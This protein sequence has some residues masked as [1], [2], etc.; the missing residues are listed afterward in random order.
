MV[1]KLDPLYPLVW[2]S[3]TSLQL[4]VAAPVVVLDDVTPADERIIAALSVGVSRPGLTMIGR[5]AGASDPAV[6]SLLDLLA[7]ALTTPPRP[8][9]AAVTITGSGITVDR[10]A[11]ALTAGGVR[12]RIA[13]DVAAASDAP[14]D[15]AIAVGHFVLAPELHG[16]WL[17]R[18][19][20]HLPVVYSDT[21]VDVGPIIEPGRGPCLYCLQRYRTD[22]DPSWPA[23]SA[24]LWGRRGSAESPLAASE[25]AALVS[26]MTLAR[27][28]AGDAASE[29][30]STEI[31]LASGDRHTLARHAHPRC[32][33]A[34]IDAVEALDQRT[35]DALGGD[36]LSAAVRP[37][38]DSPGAGR[39][40]T[41]RPSSSPSQPTTGSAS[42]WLA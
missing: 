9:T 35:V 34:G 33:C 10:I 16:L 17:R 15:F 1:L 11:E 5:A 4:G 18:D 30:L 28:D 32:G 2:R 20:P 41:S 24:Q 12:V 7:P 40:G 13:T 21:T 6:A 8:T 29:S 25:V 22:A 42:A 3:P 39:G 23:I 27:L 26:R 36:R 37:G 31:D 38:S 14:C 19:I